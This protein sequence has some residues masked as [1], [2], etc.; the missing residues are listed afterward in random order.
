MLQALLG[1]L[2]V[3]TLA[4]LGPAVEGMERAADAKAN[5]GESPAPREVTAEERSP[6]G[7]ALL[8]LNGDA[9][10]DGDQ[11]DDED[12]APQAEEGAAAVGPRSD[13]EGAVEG[14]HHVNH[15]SAADRSRFMLLL[16][17]TSAFRD[18]R[19]DLPNTIPNV[20]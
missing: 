17:S 16:L 3:A 20:K 13:A 9:A 11:G 1:C 4:A 8:D 19:I 15:S 12:G 14:V 6:E 18:L 10:S 2:S 7:A 5:E